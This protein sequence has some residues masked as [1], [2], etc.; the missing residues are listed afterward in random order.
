LGANLVAESIAL[1]TGFATIATA[2]P[3]PRNASHLFIPGIMGYQ[4][5][6]QSTP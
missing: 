4:G 6:P 3:A 5:V 2:S 1:A